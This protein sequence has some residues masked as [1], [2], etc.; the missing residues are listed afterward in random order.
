M[1]AI[2]HPKVD[3]T[4]GSRDGEEATMYTAVD[5]EIDYEDEISCFYC[6]EEQMTFSKPCDACGKNM[7]MSCTQ[8]IGGL[9]TCMLADNTEVALNNFTPSP[10]ESKSTTFKKAQKKVV[11]QGADQVKLQ[12]EA[13]WSALTGKTRTSMPKKCLL[14][15]TL[16]H[17]MFQNAIGQSTTFFDPGVNATKCD[18]A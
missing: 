2:L 5:T 11:K 12:D 15:V 13:M 4:V 9:C 8:D 7:C 18:E 16:C 10:T 3:R 1:I 14:A 6:G 17:S